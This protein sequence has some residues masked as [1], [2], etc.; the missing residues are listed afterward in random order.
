MR[1]RWECVREGLLQSV[2]TYEAER[3]FETLKTGEP[4]LEPFSSP[5]ALVS[6][7]A[8]ESADLDRKDAIYK[9]LLRNIQGRRPT[10]TLAT[11]ILWL[12]LWPGLDGIFREHL[13]YF[14]EG[15]EDLV[16]ELADLLTTSAA[17]IDLRRSRRPAATLLRNIRRDLWR[18][19]RAMWSEADLRTSLPGDETLFAKVNVNGSWACDPSSDAGLSRVRPWLDRVV[20]KDVVLL[21]RVFV[22]GESPT[23]AAVALGLLP[24]TA[25]KNF[26]RAVQK[27]SRSATETGVSRM[28][29]AR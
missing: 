8:I 5:S 18:R 23:E 21:E 24:D 20:G 2:I 11:A 16:S 10:A 25:R 12:G 27:L 1:A 9:V 26:R 4:L 14:K 28:K 7:F 3:E 17:R 13:T 15:P 19:L 22:L 29:G 6:F